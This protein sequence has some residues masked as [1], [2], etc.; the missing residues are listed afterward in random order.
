MPDASTSSLPALH[1]QALESTHTLVAGIGSEQW[2][3]PTPCDD[4]DV[5]Q[6]VNHLVAGN[7]WVV[8]LTA[9]RAIADVGDRLD[10][11]RLGD[12]P[13]HAYDRSAAAAATA[14]D[15]PG[16]MEAP[17]AVSYGPVPGSIY[18]GHRLVDVV[19]H[20][21]DIAVATGQDPS[22]DPELIE[23]CWEVV[24]PQLRELQASGMFGSELAG[25]ASPDP[26]ERL[27]A[28]LGRGV[29]AL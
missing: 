15:A 3:D 6:L 20:G 13:L 2:P 29:I 28:A 21:W 26:Q 7:L 18:A 22:L 25:P 9:G 10:G 8:E 19:V 16:A 24:R 23:A 4:W 1:R 27:L 14:F 11:D 17:C 12:L 5:R